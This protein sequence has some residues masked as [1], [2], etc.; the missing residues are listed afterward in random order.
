MKTIIGFIFLFALQVHAD[1]YDRVKLEDSLRT[2][3]EE[4][5]KIYDNK[6]HVLVRVDY[7]DF[8]GTLPGTNIISKDTFTPVKIESS[9]ISKINIELY[10]TKSDLNTETKNLVYRT[11]P[12]EKSKIAIDIKVIDNRMAEEIFKPIDGTELS[13]IMKQSIRDISFWLMGIVAIGLLAGL[14]FVF[15]INQKQLT[16]FKTQIG[17]IVNALGE[18]GMGG[19]TQAIEQAQAASSSTS[20]EASEESIGNLSLTSLKELMADCYWC[21]QDQYASWIWKKVSNEQR[22]ELLNQL[23]FMKDYSLFIVDL[24][25]NEES[26]HDHP[27]YLDPTIVC[28]ISQSDMAELV[29]QTSSLW[30]SLSPMRQNS[31]P[32]AL[33][34]KIAAVQSKP[35]KTK[36]TPTKKSPA[37]EL[38]ISSSVGDLSLDDERALME[39]PELVPLGY[40]KQVKSLVWLALQPDNSIK[41]ILARYD[42]R[43]LAAA[44]V[45]PEE[46]LSK[47]EKHLPEKKLKVLHGF[48][49]KMVPSRNSSAYI[50]LVREG[51]R[52][53][54]A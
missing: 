9:D 10:T 43:S 42:A 13:T 40:K 36:V 39:R 8:E 6:I 3:I 44:W 15:F 17:L 47:L 26:Y 31:L 2:R 54:A 16:E 52:D 18:S 14:A 4:V 7:K 53:D 21:G 29:Q 25:G 19:S 49:K 20:S 5:L 23:A 33:E 38:T 35:A 28:D 46:V 30:H 41:D 50:Q 48:T 24:K 11:I 34:A 45:G 12:I 1:L 37:R 32:L 51:W 27:Y 22:K